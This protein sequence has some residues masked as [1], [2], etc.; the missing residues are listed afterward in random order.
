MKSES[1]RW[2]LE[3]DCELR[4]ENQGLIKVFLIS[5]LAECFGAELVREKEYLFRPGANPIFTWHGCVLDIEGVCEAYMGRET[6]MSTYAKVFQLLQ[7]EYRPR[8]MIAGA[9]DSG[10]SSLSTLL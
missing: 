1:R 6:P 9:R 7:N 5:G 10:K 3:K 4:I 8:A 2:V